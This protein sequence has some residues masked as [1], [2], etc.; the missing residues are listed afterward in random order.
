MPMIRCA[1][2]IGMV[3]FTVGFVAVLVAN[4]PTFPHPLIA[5]GVTG[6]MACIA[7]LLLFARDRARSTSA[8]AKVRQMLLARPD[9]TDDDFCAHFPDADPIV[10][11]SSAKAGLPA[12]HS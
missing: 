9:V 10:V 4:D 2:M 3:A 5:G 7:A 6:G 1:T 12:R 11:T 8:V